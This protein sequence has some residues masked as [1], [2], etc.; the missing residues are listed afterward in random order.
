MSV[1]EPP[2][3]LFGHLEPL[4]APLVGI[5]QRATAYIQNRIR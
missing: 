2:C 4:I 1:D 5:G 3:A